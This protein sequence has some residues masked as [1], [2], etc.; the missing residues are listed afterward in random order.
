[1]AFQLITL[2]K[3]TFII[4][5][6]CKNNL[7]SSKKE[8]TNL[9]LKNLGSNIKKIGYGLPTFHTSLKM[10]E[11]HLKHQIFICFMLQENINNSKSMSISS[12]I[13]LTIEDAIPYSFFSL[14]A[15]IIDAC[16]TSKSN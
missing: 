9:R 5:F 12:S 4:I 8:E 15:M 3:K 11:T 7:F 6:H 16:K 1:M 2:E 10:K 14:K 13:K